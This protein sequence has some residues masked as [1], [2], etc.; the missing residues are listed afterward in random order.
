MERF[1]EIELD[2]ALVSG[3]VVDTDESYVDEYGFVPRRGYEVK[4]LNVTVWIDGLDYDITSSLSEDQRET[5]I[6][7]ILL[8]AGVE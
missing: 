3:T 8:K 4:D 1:I 2:T 5:F 7:Q 6:E